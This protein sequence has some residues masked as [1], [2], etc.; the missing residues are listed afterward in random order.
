MQGLCGDVIWVAMAGWLLF[1]LVLCEY[2]Y[3]VG[4]LR[5]LMKSYQDD[6]MYYYR[7]RKALELALYGEWYLTECGSTHS[8][9]RTR[10]QAPG[11][12]VE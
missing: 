1:G 9:K 12:F 11:R 6:A 2:R 4:Q 8:P 3:K 7:Q 5:R 10:D